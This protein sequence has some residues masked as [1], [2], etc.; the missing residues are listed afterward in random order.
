MKYSLG[1]SNF[2]EEIS[3]LLLFLEKSYNNLV[4]RL[5][6]SFGK[7]IG[8]A[9]E[10]DTGIFCSF[11]ILWSEWLL[12]RHLFCN[13]SLRCTFSFYALACCMSQQKSYRKKD[14][15]SKFLVVFQQTTFSRNRLFV[16]NINYHQFF[17][18]LKPHYP[19]IQKVLFLDSEHV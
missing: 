18:W 6:V 8:I 3:S 7:E 2:L 19:C 11:T 16:S 17:K 12:H 14:H 4:A 1:I 10:M 13:K 5:T 9:G 15:I